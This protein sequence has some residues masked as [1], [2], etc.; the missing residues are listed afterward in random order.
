M[1]LF[2]LIQN[3]NLPSE[4]FGGINVLEKLINSK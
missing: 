2:K 4:K 3:F 1:I